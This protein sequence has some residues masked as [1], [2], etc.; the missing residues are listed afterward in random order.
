MNFKQWPDQKAETFWFHPMNLFLASIAGLSHWFRLWVRQYKL[1]FNKIQT[2]RMH[3]SY[4]LSYRTALAEHIATFPLASGSVTWRN[5]VWLFWH[6]R[7]L[8]WRRTLQKAFYLWRGTG[9]VRGAAADIAPFMIDFA[10]ACQQGPKASTVVGMSEEVPR[11]PGRTRWRINPFFA[12]KIA[13]A[14]GWDSSGVFDEQL[15]FNAYPGLGPSLG[16]CTDEFQDLFLSEVN[17]LKARCQFSGV[18]VDCL[19]CFNSDVPLL[20]VVLHC[21]VW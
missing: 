1:T 9:W 5:D 21:S 8:K 14:K 7:S 19:R 2:R 20:A 17:F 11:R 13:V 3:L 16:K 4:A 18:I 15:R 10:Y 12:E 6:N